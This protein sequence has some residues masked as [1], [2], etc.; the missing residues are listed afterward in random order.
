MVD[1]LQAFRS[2]FPPPERTVPQI[3]VRQG[4]KFGERTLFAGPGGSFTFAEAPT[5]VA[6]RAGALAAA[7]F[8]KGD[9]VAILYGNHVNF[10]LTCL[11]AGWL[12]CVFLPINT[13]SK[14]PQIEYLL[15]QSGARL[16]VVEAELGDALGLVDFSQLPNLHT[17]WVNG[18]PLPVDIVGPGVIPDPGAGAPVEAA[19]V[20]PGDSFALLFTSGTSGPSKGVACP[21]AQFFWWGA[22]TTALLGVEAGEVLHTTLP[23]FHV[24][25]ANT[26]FQALLSGATI[27]VAPRFSASAFYDRLIEHRASVTYLLGAMVPILLSRPP[28]TAERSHGTTR[29]LAPGV[30]E[31][32]KAAFTERTG[33]TLIDGY[34]STETNFVIGSP[35]GEVRCAGMG[36]IVPGF[37]ARVV[38]DADN[39]IAAGE[40]GELILRAD[41]PYAFMTGYFGMPEKT[42]EAWRNLWFHTGDRVVRQADGSY[43]FVD[44]LKDA[45]RRRGENIS[46]FEVEQVLHGHPGIEVAAAFPV[47][48]ELAEDEVM[49][50]VQLVAEN[51]PTEREIVEYCAARLPYFAVPRFVDIVTDLPRT[52][53][54]KI[55]KFK[56]RE[57]GRT[58]TTWDREA[59]GIRVGR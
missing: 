34:G 20:S 25:A 44:R 50:A 3:L 28:S 19:D 9:V 15:R 1:R 57:R 46:S 52:E 53:N 37:H 55:Q 17:I 11:A 40:A 31:P 29:A 59:H 10:T 7:G 18:T 2:E 27:V 22:H 38:D 43:H 32:L 51:P 56:L 6:A 8:R 36:R 42:V 23:M 14:A 26:I 47:R 33:I 5:L 30:P 13:A 48:S 16:L 4:E 21:H 54:G 12:R 45:I 39:E 58:P 35:F 24:N 41:D 49:I